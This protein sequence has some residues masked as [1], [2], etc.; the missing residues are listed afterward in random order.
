MLRLHR[1][2][3]VESRHCKKILILQRIS[4]FR[5]Q[6]RLLAPIA[7]VDEI[8]RKATYDSDFK[9]ATHNKGCTTHHCIVIVFIKSSHIHFVNILAHC[10]FKYQRGEGILMS[11]AYRRTALSEEEIE[12]VHHL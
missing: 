3:H 10:T 5:T 6:R 9:K 7:A 11:M 2:F 4:S 12:S 1:H 8:R